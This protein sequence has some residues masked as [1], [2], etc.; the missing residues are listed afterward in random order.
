MKTK[1]N[2]ETEKDKDQAESPEDIVVDPAP[3]TEA[4]ADPR[5]RVQSLEEKLLRAKADFQNLQK[6]SANERNE[7]VRYANAELMRS[8]LGVLD[9]F[10]RS[11]SAAN[12]VEPADSVIEG[13]QLVYENLRKA[14]REHGLEP[15]VAL[16]EPF[17][18]AFHQAL[19]QKPSA[20]YPPG[21]VLEEVA[22]GYRLRDRVIR[23][24]KVIVSKAAEEK[25]E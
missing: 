17:D 19:M 9:D 3:E 1:R 24:A 21:T 12:K 20:E 8:L 6:R 25:S 11:L 4:E 13:V 10:E 14:L 7:S 2:Q 18:P 15:I 16:H 23:P 22:K 5:E